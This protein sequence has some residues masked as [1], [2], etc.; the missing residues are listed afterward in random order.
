MITLYDCAFS[1]FARKVRMVLEHKGLHFEAIDGLHAT[2]HAALAAVNPRREVPVLVDG[3]IVVLNSSHIVAYLEDAYPE[4][5]VLPAA[6]AQRVK[7][8]H[9]ERIADTLLDPIVVDASLWS[10]AKRTDLPPAGLIDA[11]RRDLQA[12]YRE[13]ETGLE[14]HG[15]FICGTFSLAD[16]ALFPNLYATRALGLGVPQEFP[17]LLEWLKRMSSMQLV[18]DDLKRV[19]EWLKASKDPGYEKTRIFWRGERI[20][21]LLAA[22][23]HQWFF[24]EIEEGR[25]IWPGTPGYRL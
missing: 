6:P 7:A 14:M 3:D 16:I 22:G 1:P 23:F 19:R 25:V 24:N 9:W 10:W 21:W 12:I 5:S 11:A 15:P 2:H 18:Q 20:E 8:R 13:L 17:L 4:P